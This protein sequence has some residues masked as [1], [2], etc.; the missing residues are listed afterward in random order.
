VKFTQYLRIAVPKEVHFE[1]SQ[2]LSIAGPGTGVQEGTHTR[3][4][5]KTIS[6]HIHVIMP[7]SFFTKTIHERPKKRFCSSPECR[8]GKQEIKVFQSCFSGL[9][10]QKVVL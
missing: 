5:T 4:H 7:T 2:T 10:G 3:K 8:I 1:V 9:K 6:I